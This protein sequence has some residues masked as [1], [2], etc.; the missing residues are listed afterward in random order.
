M[1]RYYVNCSRW[2]E[3]VA[4]VEVEAPNADIARKMLFANDDLYE[5]LVWR[6]ADG[7]DDFDVTEVKEL[8]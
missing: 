2:V 3:Q 6:D 4:T 7:V 5:A 1:K 8:S